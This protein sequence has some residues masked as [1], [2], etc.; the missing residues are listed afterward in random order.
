M[1]YLLVRFQF[2]IIAL[3]APILLRWGVLA[4]AS[5]RKGKTL[6]LMDALIA[7]TALEHALT[8]VTRNEANFAG[9]GVTILNPWM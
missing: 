2:R 3:D 1:K 7:A 6:P 8:L 5:A 4:G 9:T